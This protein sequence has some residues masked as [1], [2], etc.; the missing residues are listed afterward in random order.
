[1]RTRKRGSNYPPVPPQNPDA[2]G[3]TVLKNIRPNSRLTFPVYSSTRLLIPPV[4]IIHALYS[5]IDISDAIAVIP[6]A[7]LTN[8]LLCLKPSAF[9]TAPSFWMSPSPR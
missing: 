5:S 1:M 9:R 4:Y 3:R 8:Q 7:F 2:S 6:Q